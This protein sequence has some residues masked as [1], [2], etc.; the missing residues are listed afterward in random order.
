MSLVPP[1]L[2]ASNNPKLG[3]T[4]YPYAVQQ[5]LVEPAILETLRVW[6]EDPRE[7]PLFHRWLPPAGAPMG[8]PDWTGNIRIDPG[9]YSP[10]SAPEADATTVEDYYT[11]THW[12]AYTVKKGITYNAMDRVHGHTDLINNRTREMIRYNKRAVDI[13][14]SR[15]ILG[16]SVARN[17]FN[18]TGEFNEYVIEFDVTYGATKDQIDGSGSDPLE[19]IDD[20]IDEGEYQGSPDEFRPTLIVGQ[21]GHKALKN[22]PLMRDLI[23]RSDNTALQKLIGSVEGG[24][25]YG[26]HGV[27]VM[28]FT[29]SYKTGAAGE[30]NYERA[31]GGFTKVTTTNKRRRY[32]L[33]DPNDPT[34]ECALLIWGELGNI[35]YAQTDPRG[36][37]FG[38]GMG[39]VR[40]PVEDVKHGIWEASIE[41]MFC[42]CIENPF[43]L[44][45]LKNFCDSW[46]A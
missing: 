13:W 27:D 5:G 14:T 6:D 28:K 17:L 36:T 12:N 16:D 37:D 22:H 45:V 38:A 21:K 34:K 39:Y 1:P 25:S 20:A 44:V 26:F 35:R 32:L 9:G 42:P 19:V 23:Q 40:G 46:Q 15:F 41:H 4:G 7:Q 2:K 29:G 30:G 31:S 3:N 10:L 18:P 8:R 43:G 24:A 33:E 11:K